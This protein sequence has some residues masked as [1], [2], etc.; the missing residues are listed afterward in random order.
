MG[1]IQPVEPEPDFFDQSEAVFAQKRI[2]EIQ[3]RLPKLLAEVAAEQKKL[4]AYQDI[5]EV[6][7]MPGTQDNAR[8]SGIVSFKI[9]LLSELVQRVGSTIPRPTTRLPARIISTANVSTYSPVWP[10]SLWRFPTGKVSS[11]SS[12][13]G[14]P[15]WVLI[16]S[17][18]SGFLPSCMGSR[19]PANSLMRGWEKVFSS[20]RRTSLNPSN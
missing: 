20:P 11:R 6:T 1:V 8:P 15:F 12:Q 5:L 2:A 19:S 17:L 14:I 10:F 13:I 18:Q 7:P 9:P 4:K 16:R 3:V